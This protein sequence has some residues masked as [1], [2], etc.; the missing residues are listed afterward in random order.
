MCVRLHIYI[1]LNLFLHHHSVVGELVFA[2][3]EGTSNVF[4]QV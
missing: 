1:D 2:N 4:D 3:S